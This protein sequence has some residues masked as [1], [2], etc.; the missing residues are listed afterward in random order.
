MLKET[1]INLKASAMRHHMHTL[2]TVRIQIDL[3]TV[4]LNN[5]V[6]FHHF[7]T[8]T[9]TPGIGNFSAKMQKIGNF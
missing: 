4:F 3:E 8:L 6:F 7:G 9:N 2:L 5:R 1:K